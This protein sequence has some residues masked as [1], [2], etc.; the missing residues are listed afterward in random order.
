LI[1]LLASCSE[2]RKLA[3]FEGA[4]ETGIKSQQPTVEP[5][6]QKNDIIS[7]N[8]SSL[9]PEASSIFNAPNLTSANMQAGG[10]FST[11]GGYLVNFEGKIQFPVLGPVHVE[12]LTKAQLSTYLAQ[13]LTEKKLLVDPIIT[14]RHLNFKVSVL[15]E[16][17][18]PGVFPIASEK[19][20]ILEALGLAGDI[21]IYG[22]KDNVMLIRENEKGEK[23]VMRL[24]M[25][26]PDVLGSPY[27]Y[28]KS[29]DV[30]Y[31]EPLKDRVK[32]ER[33]AQLLPIIFSCVS[34][35]IVI[36]DRVH[37]K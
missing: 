27:Y 21:T 33:N 19:V 9:N 17:G 26:A 36:I 37:I 10:N 25:N 3:Y 11:V 35:A 31:V 20:T 30:V 12:G 5:V 16:V 14:I 15:G 34:L 13:Q 28:L 18:H 23:T 29:N 32:K 8:V 7:I 24:D 2:P 6:I 1:I 4:P 22:K